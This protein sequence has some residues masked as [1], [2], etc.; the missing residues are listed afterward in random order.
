LMMETL[1]VDLFLGNLRRGGDKRH[2]ER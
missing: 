2:G 1:F